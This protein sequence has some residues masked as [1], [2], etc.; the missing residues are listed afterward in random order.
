MPNGIQHDIADSFV[1]SGQDALDT[2]ASLKMIHNNIKMMLVRT[3]QEQETAINANPVIN[4]ETTETTES[5][6][7]EA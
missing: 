6:D 3:Q 4:A 5:A 7:V 2:L 1:L